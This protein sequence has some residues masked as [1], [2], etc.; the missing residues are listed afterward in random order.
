MPSSRISSSK[1]LDLRWVLLRKA[2]QTSG[3][4]LGG[5]VGGDPDPSMLCF[6]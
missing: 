2:I 3:S 1:S 4:P 6:D 5:D